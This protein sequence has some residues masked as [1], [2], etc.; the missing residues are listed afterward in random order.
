MNSLR[1]V[2]FFECLLPVLSHFSGQYFSAGAS[3]GGWTIIAIHDSEESWEDFRDEI[4]MPR[5]A[6]GIPVGFKT[7]PQERTFEIQTQ[8][9]SRAAQR[10]LGL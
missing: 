3:D 10:E 8:R 7:P 6:R 5:L 1:S 9:A 2:S 4:L